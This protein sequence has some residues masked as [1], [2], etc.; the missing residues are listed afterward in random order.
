M[1]DIQSAK[2]EID[3]ADTSAMFRPPMRN[4]NASLRNRDPP[5]TLHGL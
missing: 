4:C 3:M 2:S 5:Q 1:R